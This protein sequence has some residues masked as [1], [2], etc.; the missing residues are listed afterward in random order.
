ML[1]T[2]VISP[3]H[4]PL[5]RY[6]FLFLAALA[7]QALLLALKAESW[8]EAGVIAGFHIVGTAMDVFKMKSCSSEAF[9]SFHGPHPEEVRR[10]VSKGGCSTQNGRSLYFERT[11]LSH[12][13]TLSTSSV[14]QSP[15]C[16]RMGSICMARHASRS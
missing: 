7:V 3:Q 8:R 13:R 9:A 4:A 1:V 5:A 10:T 2:S 16:Q 14:V 15:R 12:Q 11:S 6:D